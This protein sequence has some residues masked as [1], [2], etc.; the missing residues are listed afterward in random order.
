MSKVLHWLGNGITWI[1]S[2]YTQVQIDIDPFVGG[3]EAHFILM[4]EI[5]AQLASRGYHFLAHTRNPRSIDAR[6]N[7]LSAEELGLGGEH[8]TQWQSY[9][10]QLRHL[11]VCLGSN[12]H[13][14]VWRCGDSLGTLSVKATY[15]FIISE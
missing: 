8:A 12:P 2:E 13:T 5:V 6:K 10:D 7:W 4:R 3:V 9:I 1:I 11:G 15:E 14:P